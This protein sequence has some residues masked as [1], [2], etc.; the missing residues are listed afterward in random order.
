MNNNL[1]TINNRLLFYREWECQK[2]LDEFSSGFLYF[3][4]DKQTLNEKINLNKLL[5]KLVYADE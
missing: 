3:K 5:T 4:V 2:N 1:I